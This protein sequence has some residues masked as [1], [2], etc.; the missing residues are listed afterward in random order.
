M[1]T[2]QITDDELIL[3]H[4]RDGLDADDRV[5][6]G[7]ALAAQPELAR[8]LQELVNRLDAAAAT[9][10]V[11]VPMETMQ[12]WRSALDARARQPALKLP[13]HR[14]RFAPAPWLAAAAT[15]VVAIAAVIQFRD[16]SPSSPPLVVEAT[17]PADTGSAYARGLQSHLASTERRLA[18]L[19]S[20]SPEER[21]RLV[22]TII[23]QNRIYAQAAERAGEPQLARV[24]RAFTPILENLQQGGDDASESVDQLAFELRVIQGRLGAAPASATPPTA[25]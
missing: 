11:P 12:R 23:E 2:T 16:Q 7:A 6:I 1:I 21:A 9:P 22:G 3:Y 14:K 10:E 20:A 24:L 18:S 15:I 25:L 4:Y 17:A 8:R 19:E 13:E 5:R